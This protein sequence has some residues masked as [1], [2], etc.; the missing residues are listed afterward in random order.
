MA[1]PDAHDTTAALARSF[2]AAVRQRREA[3][4]LRQEDI[5]FSTGIGRRFIIELEA[6]KPSCQLGK[7]LV[8]AAAVG[9]RPIDLMTAGPDDEPLL[10]DIQA[11]PD[12]D[13]G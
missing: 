3:L 11:L 5:A 13:R 7:A 10:P 2:G 1:T 4:K 12:V 6:G 8:V 9:L